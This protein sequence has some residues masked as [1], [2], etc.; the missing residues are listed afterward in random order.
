MNSAAPSGKGETRMK[1]MPYNLSIPTTKTVTTALSQSKS[2]T[3]MHDK[4]TVALTTGKKVNSS[5]DNS[6]LYCKDMRLSERADGLQSVMD[7]LSNIVSTLN[8]TSKSIDAI[9]DLL[10]L[11]KAAANSALDN[12]AYLA[13]LTGK[14]FTTDSDEPLSKLPNINAGDEIVF[15][16]GD[17]DTVA[18]DFVM[19]KDTTLKDLNIVKGEEMKIKVGD[20]DWVTLKVIDEDMKVT[21]FF[22]QVKEQGGVENFSFEIKDQKLTLTSTDRSPI[23]MDGALA[24]ALG[25]DLS[26]TY[27]ITVQD[28]WMVYDL[29]QAFSEIDG[30]SARVNPDGYFE[31]S[32]IYGDDLSIAD[33]T[34]KTA[35]S[36]GFAGCDDGG[37]NT[38]KTYA[39]R[40]NE[41][42][43]Q[44][45]NI[46]A[47]SSYNGLNLLEG[48]TIRAIF[49]EKADSYRT[50]IGVKLDAQSLGLPEA[51]ND[52]TDESDV[53]AAF[54]AIGRAFNLVQRAADK[55]ERASAMVQSRET[56]LDALSGASAL[57]A[58]TLTGADLNEV[59]A[60][61]LAI[62][63]Q[64]ELVNQ[65][66]SI[67]LDIES[68]VLSLF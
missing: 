45:N 56:F 14:N 19:N 67:T 10:S 13:T 44:I 66:I 38:S 22:G 35:K 68:S 31:V 41:L 5:Y 33:L 8:A 57:G 49:D 29:E 47:D 21:D 16:T 2:L 15:R 3:A 51:L 36:F 25:F 37:M 28:G 55:F 9:T 65:V 50:V 64:K 60:E 32:S 54:D 63:T 61:L 62:E 26:E 58:E 46:V 4:N 1:T 42:L 53:Q 34:G 6:I 12:R 52:W 39:D 43:R 17:A 30:I 20:N 11:A 7:G 23:L 18:S 48:D 59:S 40:Y 27:K 24:E